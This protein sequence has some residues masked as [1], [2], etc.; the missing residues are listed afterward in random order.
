MLARPDVLVGE[1]TVEGRSVGVG[2]TSFG[3]M[4]G[5]DLLVQHADAVTD[6][7]EDAPLEW[8]ANSPLPVTYRGLTASG[9]P[10]GSRWRRPSERRSSARA[11]RG[12][13][14]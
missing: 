3:W 11:R 2:H 1:W 5:A 12:R 4:D 14:T 13:V 8:Q 7:G 10:G 6:A 9:Q